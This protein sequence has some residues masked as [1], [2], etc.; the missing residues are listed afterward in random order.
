MNIW[1][2]IFFS[3]IGILILLGIYVEARGDEAPNNLIDY[4]MGIVA[5]IILLAIPIAFVGWI[6]SL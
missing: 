5:A 3:S 2:K 1:L 4:F 6:F